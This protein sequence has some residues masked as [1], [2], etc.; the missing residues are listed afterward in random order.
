MSLLWWLVTRI[1]CL[2]LACYPAKF[3]VPIQNRRSYSIT[4][5]PETERWLEFYQAM[6]EWIS[7]VIALLSPAL[8]RYLPTSPPQIENLNTI[9]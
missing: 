9:E 3:L 6:A 5:P 2:M 7:I 4:H 1:Y 8:L